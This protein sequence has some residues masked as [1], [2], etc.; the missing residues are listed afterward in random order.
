MYRIIFLLLYSMSLHIGT[1]IRISG[2]THGGSHCT[3]HLVDVY[4]ILNSCRSIDRD[5]NMKRM[6]VCGSTSSGDD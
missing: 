6:N 1:P 4:V 2:L 3:S 5:I